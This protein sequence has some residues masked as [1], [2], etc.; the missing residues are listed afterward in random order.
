MDLL[1]PIF[2]TTLFWLTNGQ[3][4]SESE[5]LPKECGETFNEDRIIGG[6]DAS[7][8]QYPW[9]ARVGYSIED[10]S[11][12]DKYVCGGSLITD[13]YVVTAAHCITDVSEMSCD[14]KPGHSG[15]M[16]LNS[17]LLG[18]HNEKTEIDC[19]SKGETCAPKPQYFKIV[20]AAYHGLYNQPTSRHDIAVLKLDKPAINS[21]FVFP[22]CLP[23]Q[24]VRPKIGAW[25]E[26][27]GWGMTNM[28][29]LEVSDTL[30]RLSIPLVE[31]SE[32]SETF[33]K[34]DIE[35]AD[36]QICAGGLANKDS[37][38]GDSGGP[39]MT[40]SDHNGSPRVFLMG[41]VSF[42]KAMCGSEDIPAVYTDVH[43]YAPWILSQISND[44]KKKTKP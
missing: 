44:N 31:N 5:I 27:A 16:A 41:V 39:L 38:G 4:K 32:C 29:T 23:L 22:I 14:S 2:I 36:T 25:L 12:E 42:G 6:T 40:V 1:L 21:D 19:E 35:I 34:D 9:I 33:K 15:M 17:V 7:L 30:Q 26:V 20:K 37:C 24:S 8:G 11:D 28:T 3:D 43:K 10:C 13:R 18:E